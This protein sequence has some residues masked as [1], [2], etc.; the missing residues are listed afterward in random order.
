MGVFRKMTDAR[1]PKTMTDT[2]NHI[3]LLRT[4]QSRALA[5]AEAQTQRLASATERAAM[6]EGLLSNIHELCDR[7]YKDERAADALRLMNTVGDI[8]L[9]AAKGKAP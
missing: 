4:A 3:E 6:L 2:L 7:V 9:I 5:H 1:P 8:Q